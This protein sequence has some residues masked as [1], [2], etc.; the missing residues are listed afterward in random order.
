MAYPQLGMK[1]YA[2]IQYDTLLEV[3]PGKVSL[4]DDPA[5]QKT[6]VPYFSQ[7][8]EEI[9]PSFIVTPQ[10]T[11]DVSV[12]VKALASVYE[13]SSHTAQFAIRGRGHTP[14]AGSASLEGGVVIEMTSMESMTMNADES[15]ISVG[16]GAKWA[17]VYAYLS[18]KNLTVCGGRA[19]TVGVGGLTLGGLPD[20]L[21][22]FLIW[23]YHLTIFRW[24]LILFGA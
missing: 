10:N 8:A 24:T 17:D 2:K 22:H 11:N 21:P 15:I 19:P 9:P 20:F 18:P 1:S 5:Y 6:R 7:Q 16:A 14:F 23:S 12:A 13:S 4:R 3:L